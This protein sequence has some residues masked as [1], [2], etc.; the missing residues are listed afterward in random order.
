MADQC[1]DGAFSIA[2]ISGKTGEAVAQHM[3]SDFGGLITQLGDPQPHLRIA[4]GRP[5][6]STRKHQ[7]A[8]PRLGLDH[9]A[10]FQRQ[11]TKRCVGLGIGQSCCSSW[12]IDLRPSQAQHFASS[13]TGIARWR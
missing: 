4:D 9:R 13:L 8:V 12:H 3:R 11:C 2:Q 7:I 1:R 5:A 10:G 6:G